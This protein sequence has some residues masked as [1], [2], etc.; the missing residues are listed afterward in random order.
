MEWKGEE[1]KGEDR[2]GNSEEG[3]WKEK[4]GREG[5]KDFLSPSPPEKIGGL[6]WLQ[7]CL[8]ACVAVCVRA[9]VIVRVL[10]AYVRVSKYALMPSNMSREHHCERAN[11]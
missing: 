5:S 9:C 11:G 8:R 4:E 7:V 1:R 6:L 2:G 10:S 3:K